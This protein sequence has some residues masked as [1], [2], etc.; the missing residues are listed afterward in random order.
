[1]GGAA[2]G[3]NERAQQS[4]TGMVSKS[5]L[6]RMGAQELFQPTVPGTERR[7]SGG[8]VKSACALQRADL[9]GFNWRLIPRL[10]QACRNNLISFL[11]Y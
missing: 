3:G 1:M 5:T 2:S 11:S 9:R 7:P 8:H 6:C 10:D 4:T